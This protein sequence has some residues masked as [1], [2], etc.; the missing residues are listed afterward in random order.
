VCAYGNAKLAR[1]SH[2]VAHHAGVTGVEP[3][4]DVCRC[5]VAH[6]RRVGVRWPAARALTEVSVQVNPHTAM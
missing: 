1:Q 5:D 6:Q 4:G 3:T 2:G